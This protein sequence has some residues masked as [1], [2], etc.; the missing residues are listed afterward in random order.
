MVEKRSNTM[1]KLKAIFS[2]IEFKK[3]LRH[4]RITRYD[5]MVLN[6]K[7]EQLEVEKTTSQRLSQSSS[8]STSEVKIK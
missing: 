5:L 6:A 8:K 4:E 3:K 2:K 1:Q 7:V